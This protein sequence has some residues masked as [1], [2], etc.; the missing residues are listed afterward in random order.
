MTCNQQLLMITSSSFWW[1]ILVEQSIVTTNYMN[2][3][4][5]SMV[6]LLVCLQVIILNS[7]WNLE[8]TKCNTAY[9]YRFVPII[10]YTIAEWNQT[11]FKMNVYLTS[12]LLDDSSTYY[13]HKLVFTMDKPI[14]SSCPSLNTWWLLDYNST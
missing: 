9:T 10:F 13:M 7:R 12:N 3:Y 1:K 8:Y 14:T 2:S 4:N 5:I 6:N 11:K